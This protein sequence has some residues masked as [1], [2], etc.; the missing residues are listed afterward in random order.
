V[1]DMLAYCRVRDVPGR[2]WFRCT[3]QTAFGVIGTA[4]GG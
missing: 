4:L 2:E 1:H 3:P